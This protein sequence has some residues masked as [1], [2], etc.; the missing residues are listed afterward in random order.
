MIFKDKEIKYYDAL[1]LL[2]TTEKNNKELLAFVNEEKP[3]I[4]SMLNQV[5]SGKKRTTINIPKDKI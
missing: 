4:K 5:F 3:K 1:K 2:S